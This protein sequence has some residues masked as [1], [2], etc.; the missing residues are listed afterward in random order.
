MKALFVLPEFAR[1][2]VQRVLD[3]AARRLLAARINRDPVGA[4]AR[5]DRDAV[6]DCADERAP[7]VEDEHVPVVRTHSDRR[8]DRGL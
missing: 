3:G 8:H 4:A 2:E 5:G 6:D 7:L 1:A